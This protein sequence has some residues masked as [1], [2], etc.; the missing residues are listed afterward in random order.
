M[1]KDRLYSC[2][3]FKIYIG[4]LLIAVEIVWQTDRLTELGMTVNSW[5]AFATKN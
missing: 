1:N 5:V 4:W 2:T 3:V